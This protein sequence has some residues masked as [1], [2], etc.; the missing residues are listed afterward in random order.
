MADPIAAKYVRRFVGARELLHNTQRHCLWLQHATPSDLKNSPVLR[1]RV[2]AA[3]KFR[4]ESRA[5]STR[6]A[7]DTAHTFRQ[8][9]QPDTA[10][11]CIPRH[12]SETRPYFLAQR[13]GA[14]VICGDANFL[15]PDPD[16]FI[17]AAI[18]STMFLVW[19]RT[20][21]GRIKSD[22]RFNK[23]LAWN[24][25]PLPRIDKQR[26]AAIIAAGQEVLDARSQQGDASL[27]QMYS[28]L[29]LTDELQTAHDH[30]DEI[31]DDLFGL[32]GPGA[33]ELERQDSAL[34]PLS[35]H[36]ETLTPGAVVKRPEPES[37]T[38]ARQIRDYPRPSRNSSSLVAPARGRRRSTRAQSRAMRRAL[39]HRL[40]R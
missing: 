35:G 14:E 4:A 29:L 40:A 8:I 9:A 6:A 17:F 19:Q 28:P 7:A 34:R 12:V 18:S 39:C 11:L 13:F 24:T 2:A 30:L 10:Y 38:A 33:T 20:I 1:E 15:S 36:C 32:P 16:G 27:A 23:L 21:G 3:R 22:L 25:F 37:I 26:R 5:E 31:F